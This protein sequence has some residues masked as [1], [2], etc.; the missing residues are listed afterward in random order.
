MVNG[1]AIRAGGG[2]ISYCTWL[3][4]TSGSRIRCGLKCLSRR[5]RTGGPVPVREWREWARSARRIRVWA[6]CT[7][8][9][10]VWAWSSLSVRIWTWSS[11]S[12]RVWAWCTRW[13]SIRRR[14]RSTIERHESLEDET[15]DKGDNERCL[16][17]ILQ[18]PSLV[19]MQAEKALGHFPSNR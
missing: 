17:Y 8:S 9:I 13:C 12:I 4:L 7:L 6:R 5:D 19:R 14:A 10:R 11:L 3:D 1:S 2:G 16:I 15:R 18:R